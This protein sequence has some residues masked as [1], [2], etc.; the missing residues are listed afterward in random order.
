MTEATTQQ[1]LESKSK[2]TDEK[3]REW[4]LRITFGE[5]LKLKT[6]FGIDVY[7]LFTDT[8]D[9]LS[10]LLAEEWKLMEVVSFLTRKQREAQGVQDEDFLD[11]FSGDVLDGA[12]FA[13]LYG[14]A[15]SLKKSQRR[16]MVLLLQRMEAR[17]QTTLEKL[18]QAAATL[19]ER[20]MDNLDST[21]GALG[22]GVQ[23][24][25]A[26]IHATSPSES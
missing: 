1:D 4:S 15:A 7:K 25:S 3:G 8:E 2:F 21:I 23:E 22:S 5:A 12:T 13:F 9:Q 19:I 20:E 26:S 11:G 17:Q 16:A 6:D 24:S 10:S 18:D 14:V